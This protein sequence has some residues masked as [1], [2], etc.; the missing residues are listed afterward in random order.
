[1]RPI[2]PLIAPAQRSSMT[3]RRTSI[4]PPPCWGPMFGFTEDDDLV[5]LVRQVHR[6]SRTKKSPPHQPVRRCC[7]RWRTRPTTD[8]EKVK[9][10]LRSPHRPAADGAQCPGRAAA[11]RNFCLHRLSGGAGRAGKRCPPPGG[12]PPVCLLLRHLRCRRHLGA[13]ARY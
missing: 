1:M 4:R 5:R 2:R 8:R 13:G 9:D 12:C 7:W 3:P 6:P 11:G 10:F